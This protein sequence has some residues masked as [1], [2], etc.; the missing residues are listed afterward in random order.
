M[1]H[2]KE[3]YVVGGYTLKLSKD[4]G[5]SSNA[6]LWE[7]SIKSGK[8]YLPLYVAELQFPYNNRFS[9][10]IFGTAVGGC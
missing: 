9:A 1:D 6:A 10:D 4:F 3:Q 5:R 7:A 8:R 2:A